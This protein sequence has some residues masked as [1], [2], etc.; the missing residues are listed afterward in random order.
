MP[1]AP[2][3]SRLRPALFSAGYFPAR[4]PIR[5]WY[6]RLRPWVIRSAIMAM[7]AM[8]VPATMP[9]RTVL[10]RRA[11]ALPCIL[12]ATQ[13]TGERATRLFSSL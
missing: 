6:A 7:N 2:C 9:G 13:W 8:P 12:V 11:V 3:S 5:S 4:K 10:V 1:R